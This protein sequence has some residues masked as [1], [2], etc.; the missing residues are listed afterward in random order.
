MSRI[1]HVALRDFLATVM[2]K[3]FI[4]GLLIAPAIGG[5]MFLVGPWL[6]D[7]SRYR[8]EGEYAVVDPTGAVLPAMSA[9]LDPGAVAE[10]RMNEFRRT[11]GDAPEAVRGMAEAAIGQSMDDALGPAPDV[12][13][14]A[15]PADADVEAAKAW[16]NEESD[17]PRHT[18]LIVIH[19]HAVA[20]GGAQGLG[21]YDLFVPPGLDE[22]DLDFIHD[23]VRDAIVDARV[24]ARSL[25][26][27]ELDAL[28][29]VPRPRSTTVGP[30]AERETVGGL[31]TMLPMAFMILMFIGV[32]SGGQ[33]MLTSMIEEKSTRVVEVLLSAVSPMELMAGKLIGGVAITLVMLGLYIAMG[34]ALLATFSLFGL[35]D[36]WLIVYLAIFFL[37]GFFL[38]GS[39]ML[40]VG[41]AVNDM[42]EAQ[43]LQMPL[44]LV[45]MVP[46]F[47]WPAVSRN[48]GS[49]FAVVVSHLPPLNTFGMLLRLGSS[50]PP[51]WWEVWLSIA[52]GL[53]SVVAA[54]WV[55]AKVFRIGLLMYGKPPDLKTLIRWVRAA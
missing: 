47:I 33:T 36:P 32:M 20:A 45:L 1:L 3:G 55:A 42:T 21:S 35:L 17:G 9:A 50:Q 53:A 41:A 52:V 29:R 24:A 44:M 2:T 18:A 25:D 13:L 10:R 5:V 19:E 4:I 31:N 16:L 51:P 48:P 38:F 11:L 37:I 8:I 46:W 43:T 7:D 54:V 15:L 23:S 49:T 39:L 22:R 14:R 12:R 34:L 40:A 30:D 26:R 6:F 27:G 28:L